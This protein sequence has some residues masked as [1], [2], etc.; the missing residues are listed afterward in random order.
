MVDPI[1][2]TVAA[3]TGLAAA[4]LVFQL[5][6]ALAFVRDFVVDLVTS[7]VASLAGLIAGLYV[8]Y[9]LFHLSI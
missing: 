1:A 7:N 9:M 8:V 5:L 4:Y 2:L 6:H 3:V